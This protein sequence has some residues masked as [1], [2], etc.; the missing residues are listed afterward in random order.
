VLFSL[1]VRGLATSLI[2]YGAIYEGIYYGR[3]PAYH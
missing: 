1:R 3:A 2:T